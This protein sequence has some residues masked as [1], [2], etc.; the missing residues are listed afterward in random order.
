MAVTPPGR[1]IVARVERDGG[2]VR[3]SEGGPHAPLVETGAL[4]ANV[5]SEWLSV[6]ADGDGA[7]S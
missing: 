1:V 4:G 3:L 7:P 5:T 2:C 6:A